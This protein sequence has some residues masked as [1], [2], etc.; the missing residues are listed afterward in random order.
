MTI[1]AA[2][3]MMR[4]E[5]DVASHVV[6]HFVDEG[7]D[8]IIVADNNSVDGTRESLNDLVDYAG[9]C[10]VVLEVSD[11]PEVG[12]YQSKK[13]TALARRAHEEYG[14]E[15]IIPF[16]ADELWCHSDMPLAD[17]LRKADG[18]VVGGL[19][20]NHYATGIDDDIPNPFEAMQWR[21][22]EAGA[23][24]KVAVR[25]NDKLTI[26]QGN[27]SADVTG[28]GPWLAPAEFCEIRHFPYRSAAQFI[29]KGKNG[30]EAYERAT[31]LRKDMG[32]H[33]RQY[34]EILRR[35]G[36]A[37]LLEVFYE[38]YHF[39]APVEAGMIHDP[40]PFRRWG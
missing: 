27:H 30:A 37:A 16:D 17:F 1:V 9:A 20:Y 5:N 10:G 14:A 7:V 3:S 39:E 31:E 23:L 15:W 6:K 35:H 11:D 28:G 29:Q 2:V 13:M 21:R 26:H 24:P 40:A 25:W 12:Y 22:P 38:W 4:D 32:A 33:W 19:M 8:V 18:D 34:G 36:E